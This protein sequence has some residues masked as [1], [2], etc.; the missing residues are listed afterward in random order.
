MFINRK[1]QIYYML[2]LLSEKKNRI[3]EFIM[4]NPT[5]EIKI[6]ELARELGVSHAYI[7][8]ILK[9]LISYKMLKNNKVDLSNPYVRALKIFFNVKKLVE[10]DVIKRLKE[11][12]ATSAG[13]YGSWAN[14]T[15]N[16]DSDL[17]IW[18]K[19]D[20]QIDE[21]K[22]ASILN[23]IRRV[24]GKNVQILVLTKERIEKLKKEDPIFYY[25]LVFGSIILYGEGI[26]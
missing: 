22:V 25:S 7:S 18:I 6:R 15:N 5:K 10:K 26:E 23:K 19:T 4:D 17:D 13:I 9:I 21:M 20:K 16:E 24:I 8:K 2:T 1:Q 12:K 3:L 14:G 11:L